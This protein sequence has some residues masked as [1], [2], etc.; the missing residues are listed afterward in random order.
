MVVQ[1]VKE[2]SQPITCKSKNRFWRFKLAIISRMLVACPRNLNANR[3]IPICTLLLN[4]SPKRNGIRIS[5]GVR[6]RLK[7]NIIMIL[8]NKFLIALF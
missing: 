7:I 2:I 3:K 8:F 5:V 4:S 1:S 6:D